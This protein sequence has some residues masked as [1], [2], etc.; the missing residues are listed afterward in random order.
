MDQHVCLE[1]RRMCGGVGAL[2]ANERFFSWMNQHVCFEN[3]R[4]C[5][6]KC[7]LK[8]FSPEWISMWLWDEKF[9]QWS[10]YIVCKQKASQHYE[11]TYGFSNGLANH[12]C[13]RIG[14]NCRTSFYHSESS[15]DGLQNC[16]FAFPVFQP[17]TFEVVLGKWKFL[18]DIIIKAV[19]VKS[20]S[21]EVK[22]K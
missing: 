11:P 3:R 2:S 16:L 21:D 6:G 1:V 13:S 22:L 7:A 14:C 10:N 9:L 20:L 19:S 12:M 5:A 4:V 8:G 18:Q 15:Y 17:R